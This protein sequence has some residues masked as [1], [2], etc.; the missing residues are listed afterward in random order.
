M[1]EHSGEPPVRASD[2][3]EAGEAS[4][5]DTE[6]ETSGRSAELA[7]NSGDA[8]TSAEPDEQLAATSATAVVADKPITKRFEGLHPFRGT[9]IAL[10]GSVVPFLL[11][12]SDRHFGFS[13]AAGS[14]SCAIAMGG[15]LDAVGAFDEREVA[16][17]ADLKKLGPRL[18]ELIASGIVLVACL[19]LSVSGVL[20][21]PIATAALFITASF[22]WTVVATFRAGQ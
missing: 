15:F 12:A 21:K 10:L 2:G 3:A 1:T 8:E 11:M 9:L 14:V 7:A 5:V 13:V 16:A 22:L 19:R 4:R 6:P 20:P 18:I 17:T